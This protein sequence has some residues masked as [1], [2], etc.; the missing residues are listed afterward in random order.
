[1]ALIPPD[2]TPVATSSRR[3]SRNA[4]SEPVAINE[5][6]VAEEIVSD[7]VEVDEKTVTSTVEDELKTLQQQQEQIMQRLKELQVK[8]KKK[9]SPVLHQTLHDSMNHSPQS[10][11]ATVSINRLPQPSD[12]SLK[13]PKPSEFGGNLNEN[14]LQWITRLEL[15]LDFTGT[16]TE[17]W[18]R[19][20]IMYLTSNA[21][22]WIVGYMKSR[23]VTARDI[24]WDEFKE[25]FLNMGQY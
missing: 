25:Q 19:T 4:D 21:L 17:D 8:T 24:S 22:Q 11:A 2:R 13:A 18:G 1:M 6:N 15:Y 7:R 10:S 9:Q 3:T 23:N 14:A 16:P 20:A 12:R 5:S